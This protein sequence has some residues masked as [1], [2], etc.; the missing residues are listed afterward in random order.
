[1]K[2]TSKLAI[3]TAQFGLNYGISNKE[4][5]TNFTEVCSILKRAEELDI[6][7]LDTAR[8]YADSEKI[9][10]KCVSNN[11]QI[12]S[13]FS[14]TV[15][16]KTDL[17]KN[18]DSTLLNLKSESV[19]GYLAHD[20]ATLI[21][22]P[23]IWDELQK[24]KSEGYIK[25]TGCS[26]YSPFE[27]ELLLKNDMIPDIIQFPYSFVDRRFESY[28]ENIKSKNC[29]IHTRSVFLQGLLFLNAHEISDFFKPIKPLLIEL[30]NKFST[31]EEIAGFLLK[32]VLNNKFIDKLI[33]GI[34]N[35][36]Q[37]ND[38]IDNIYMNLA[39][40][41]IQLKERIPEQILL[42]YLWPK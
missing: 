1:M 7:T 24:I 38:N 26:I 8:D 25:K 36:K 14:N 22:N 29:E 41:N 11:F 19:Y 40:T 37:L 39:E 23:H 34:N 6:N 3:G 10:G 12:I 4:G 17:R 15:K 42:P 13:K 9:I 20:I 21:K 32:F 33:F 31:N 35:E 2:I 27:L 5:Q 28:F 18:I 16:T 30:Q